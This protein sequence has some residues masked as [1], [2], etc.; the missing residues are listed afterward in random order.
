MKQTINKVNITGVLVKVGLEKK[1]GKKG[2]FIG[3]DLVL[4]TAD[5]SEHEVSYYANRLTKDG[6]ESSLYKGLQT[7]MNEYKSLEKFPNDADVIQIGGSEFSINDY[8]G[9]DGEVKS[10]VKVNAKFANRLD[11]IKQETTPLE[12]IFEAEGIITKLQP[13]VYKTEPTGNGEIYMDILGYEGTIIPVKLIVPENMVDAFG[14]AGFYE[15]GVAKF[16]GKLINTKETKEIIEK[17]TF[18]ADIKKP[19]TTTVR[20]FEVAGGSPKGTIYDYQ[21]TD[22]EYEQ[23]KSKRRLKLD[24]IKNKVASPQQGFTPAQTPTTS[25]FANQ[26]SNNTQ[27]AFNPFAS[28]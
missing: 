13:E 6:R 22:D 9:Q 26:Q 15:S 3:G 20:R 14:Q 10:F 8:K 18:G 21:I 25:P 16:S 1:V 5:G 11:S 28:K 19:V 4:R 7:V 2:E 17:Q 24:E 27:N 23:A 12:A